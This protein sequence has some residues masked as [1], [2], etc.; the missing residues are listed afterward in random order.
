MSLRNIKKIINYCVLIIG[1]G[2]WESCNPKSQHVLVPVDN[3]KFYKLYENHDTTTIIEEREEESQEVI[4][5]Y[6]EG[7]EIFTSSYGGHKELLMST[8]EMLDTVYSEN[9]YYR[10]HRIL[11]KKENSNLFSTSIYNIIV[12]PVLVLTIYYDHSYNIKAIRNWFAY[13]TYKSEHEE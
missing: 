2:V 1:L 6:Q 10:E 9:T 13:T 8:T 4:K 7:S 11:I 5:F 12:Q 3:V